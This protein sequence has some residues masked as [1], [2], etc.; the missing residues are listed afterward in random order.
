MSPSFDEQMAPF[1]RPPRAPVRDTERKRQELSHV[2]IRDGEAWN[3]RRLPEMG[4]A[5]QSAHDEVVALRNVLFELLELREGPRD[6]RY[7]EE[8]ERAWDHSRE[9]LEREWPVQ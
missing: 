8:K 9:L 4:R 2:A 7:R 1:P 5:L 6:R 3:D